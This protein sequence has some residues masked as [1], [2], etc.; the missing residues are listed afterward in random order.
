MRRDEADSI[1]RS[2]LSFSQLQRKNTD[3]IGWIA[4][5]YS[6]TRATA[7]QKIKVARNTVAASLLASKINKKKK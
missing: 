6:C 1:V 2:L 4:M 7:E 3:E 5:R